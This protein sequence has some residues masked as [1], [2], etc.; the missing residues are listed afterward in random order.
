MVTIFLKTNK[1]I[2]TK[3]A[4]KQT[5]MSST[6]KAEKTQKLILRNLYSF[7]TN[8]FYAD[9]ENDYV[10]GR[11]CNNGMS[12]RADEFSKKLTEEVL[13]KMKVKKAKNNYQLP[14]VDGIDVMALLNNISIK[15]KKEVNI[16]PPFNLEIGVPANN[17]EEQLNKQNILFDPSVIKKYDKI[18]KSIVRLKIEKLISNNK[19]QKLIVEIYERSTNHVYF[20]YE[21]CTDLE[22]Q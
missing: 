5:K 21:M 14:S 2:S 22:K 7:C 4:E 1:M 6:K 18:V 10:N 17:I 20:I 19:A 12:K 15:E 8:E 11:G 3:K 9:F 13:S 16:P